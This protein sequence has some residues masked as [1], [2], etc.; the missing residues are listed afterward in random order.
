[1][2]APRSSDLKRLSL[3]M[4]N[5]PLQSECPQVKGFDIGY[6]DKFGMP[7]L[8]GDREGS[9]QL[10]CKNANDGAVTEDL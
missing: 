8:W 10:R 2:P 6:I 3:K 1:M 5:L 9:P 7:F 4:G